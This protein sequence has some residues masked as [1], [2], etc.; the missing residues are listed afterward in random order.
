[1]AKESYQHGE[2]C[3]FHDIYEVW[4]ARRKVV[5]CEVPLQEVHI[6]RNKS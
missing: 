2:L 3:I 4:E 6:Y 5:L 1:M